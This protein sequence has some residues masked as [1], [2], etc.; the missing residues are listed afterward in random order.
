MHLDIPY[1]RQPK[2]SAWCGAASAAMILKWY[3]VSMTQK[4]IAKE[5]PITKKGVSMGRL[6]QFFLRKGFDATVQFW[7]QGLEPQIRGLQGNIENP[8]LIKALERGIR[9]KRHSRTRDI[10]KE[11]RT[12]VKCGGNIF[13]EPILTRD[14]EKEIRRKHPIILQ[15]D[16]NFPDYV[17]RTQNGHY[18]VI[19]GTSNPWR[20]NS[21]LTWPCL[22]VHDPGEN[23][24]VFYCFDELLY[25]CHMW[26]GCAL[27]VKP[28]T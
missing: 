20:S 23:A 26:Y 14:I 7:L 21:Q 19:N 5:L 28:K 11:M 16:S 17:G 4:Q 10:C 12:F 1:V 9:Q 3:G 25:S 24:D 13:L 15:I 2:N 22:T 18:V 27:F 8:F 6:G